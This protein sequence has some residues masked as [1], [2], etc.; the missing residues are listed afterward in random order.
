[1]KRPFDAIF[2]SK[3]VAERVRGNRTYKK[4]DT[5]VTLHNSNRLLK[6]IQ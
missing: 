1:M 5:I 2:E 4:I 6:E 3:D